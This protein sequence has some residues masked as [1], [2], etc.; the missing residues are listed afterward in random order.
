MKAG[1]E[2]IRRKAKLR[3]WKYIVYA[4]ISTTHLSK[5][6]TKGSWH[7]HVIFYGSPCNVIAE[8]LKSYWTKHGYGNAIQCKLQACWDGKKINYVRQQQESAHFQKVNANDI[9]SSLHLKEKAG[10]QEILNAL[11]M[12]YER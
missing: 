9:L 12:S 8:T 10:K 2:S 6:N 7:V 3:A 1:L 4:C 5:G 11:C